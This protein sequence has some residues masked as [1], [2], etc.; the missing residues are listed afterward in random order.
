MADETTPPAKGI[1]STSRTHSV[2][3]NRTPDSTKISIEDR[4][5][6]TGEQP[7][8]GADQLS[9]AD[10]LAAAAGA[11]PTP[12]SHDKPTGGRPS[13]QLVHAAGKPAPKPNQPPA[14]QPG[15]QPTTQGEPGQSAETPSQDQ[16]GTQAPTAPQQPQNTP[17]KQPGGGSAKSQ[18][19]GSSAAGV[20]D[21]QPTTQPSG[22]RIRQTAEQIRARAGQAR[23]AAGQALKNFWKSPIFWEVLWGVIVFIVMLVAI[24]VAFYFISCTIKGTCTGGDANP[25]NVNVG[26]DRDAILIN[27]AKQGNGQ[28][29]TEYMRTHQ[30]EIILALGQQKAN[31]PDAANKEIIQKLIA[32]I[33]ALKPGTNYSDPNLPPERKK[34]KDAA[35]AA[36]AEYVK[37]GGTYPEVR[38]YVNFAN[39]HGAKINLVGDGFLDGRPGRYHLGYDMYGPPGSAIIVGWDGVITGIGNYDASYAAPGALG[40]GIWINSQIDDQK[41]SISYGHITVDS[42]IKEG[43]SVKAGDKIGVISPKLANP[44]LD[45]KWKRISDNQWVD[46]G[47]VP[48]KTV[49]ELTQPTP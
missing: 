34:E 42:P 48:F 20:P 7:N 19:T 38:K 13:E 8:T 1:E 3:V 27:L 44:H 32:A 33:G 39:Q 15:G 23:K 9:A 25:R 22:G 21:K 41:Y 37:I 40:Q 29:K 43:Q 4:S 14:Q 2:Q 12:A 10:Q 18:P 47:R 35:L 5:T 31:E 49:A 17:A 11:A 30:Q 45:T 46:W 26:S 6:T 24:G 36:Y 28:A 16:P